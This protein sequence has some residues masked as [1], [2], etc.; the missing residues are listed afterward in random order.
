MKLINI[1]KIITKYLDMEAYGQNIIVKQYCNFPKYLPLPAHLEHG[2]TPKSGALISDLEVAKHKN[3]ML[4][5]SQRRKD[6]WVKK[7]RI[8]VEIIGSPFIFYKKMMGIKQTSR[9]TGTVVFPSHSTILMES[10]YDI[11]DYCKQLKKLPKKFH[12]IEICLFCVDI[13]KGKDAIYKKYGF[14]VISA[15]SRVRGSLNF[16]RNFY[17][18]IRNL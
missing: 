4:V 16:A 11:G 12:P 6:A 15:G 7:S 9:A 18:Q 1:E 13:Q 8:R 2:W 17:T 10:K 14:R 5:F 3:L